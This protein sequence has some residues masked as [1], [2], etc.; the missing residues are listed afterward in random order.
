MNADMITAALAAAAAEHGL[1]SC[2]P[3]PWCLRKPAGC[4]DCIDRVP[5]DIRQAAEEL[6]GNDPRA[7]S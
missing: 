6:W 7:R 5:E 3:G 2:I 1:P 4:P